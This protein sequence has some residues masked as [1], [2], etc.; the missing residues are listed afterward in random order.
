MYSQ[1]QAQ[2]KLASITFGTKGFAY[3]LL[4]TPVFDHTDRSDSDILK[5]VA[6][7]WLRSTPKG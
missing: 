2:P 3:R 4:D 6:F 5:D 1:L 7:G